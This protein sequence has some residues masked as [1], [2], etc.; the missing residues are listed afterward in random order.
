MLR[1]LSG[2]HKGRKQE[3]HEWRNSGPQECS[4]PTLAGHSVSSRGGAV[5][6]TL[7]P[8]SHGKIFTRPGCAPVCWEPGLQG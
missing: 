2:L 8:D 6:W 4:S 3:M 5:S 7:A 1:T